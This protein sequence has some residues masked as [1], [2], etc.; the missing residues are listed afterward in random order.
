MLYGRAAALGGTIS[1]ILT[2]GQSMILDVI[3]LDRRLSGLNRQGVASAAFSFVEKV[4]YAVGPALILGLLAAYGFD[5]SLPRDVMQSDGAL[6]AITLGMAW[7]PA[8]CSIGMILVLLFYNLTEEKIAATG[9]ARA[10]E[11][12]AA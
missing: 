8:A 6:F 3:E 12:S 4:M 2:C 10:S 1:G 11:A 9:T 5:A 7:I